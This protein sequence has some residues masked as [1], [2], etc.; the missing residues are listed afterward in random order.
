MLEAIIL[1]VITAATPLLLAA[2]GELVVEAFGRPQPWRGGE[3]VMGG[4]RRLR[5]HQHD[6]LDAYRPSAAAC[7]PALR[8]PAL[9]LRHADARRQSGRLRLGAHPLRT[10]LSGLRWRIVVGTP[11]IKLP[12]L[13]IPGLTGHSFLRPHSVR[14]GYPG[15][16]SSRSSPRL[17]TCCSA[18]EP[19]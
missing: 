17:P 4:R 11:G 13:D 8:S 5:T 14:P 3:M 12:A 1:T 19:G 10:R 7:L 6:R 9:R 2:I 16:V 15:Y 18:P